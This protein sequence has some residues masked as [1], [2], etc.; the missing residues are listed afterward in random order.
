MPETKKLITD[1]VNGILQNVVATLI[2]PLI[3]VVIGVIWA[4][5]SKSPQTILL[6]ILIFLSLIN[7]IIGFYTLRALSKLRRSLAESA[8]QDNLLFAKDESKPID[9]E[10]RRAFRIVDKLFIE[11]VTPQKIR[12]VLL[13]SA[14]NNIRV[15]K[16]KYSGN[17]LGLPD[18][19]IADIYRRDEKGDFYIP[20]DISKAEVLPGQNFIVEIQLG[21]VWPRNKINAI[22]GNWGYLTINAIYKDQSSEW[23]K[24]I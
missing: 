17:S 5:T 11:D 3:I 2:T 12:L 7:V 23:F 20:F 21:Q 8:K 4:F 16:V 15:T 14:N 6:A 18:T 1:Q 24:G 19:A 9:N 22:T 10:L 13:N